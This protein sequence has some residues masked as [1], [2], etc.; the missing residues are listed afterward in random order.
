MRQRFCRG[1]DVGRGGSS[2]GRSTRTRAHR[3]EGPDGNRFG[4]PAG[5]GRGHR[6]SD[7]RAE[8]SAAPELFAVRTAVRPSGRRADELRPVRIQRNFTKHAE[9]AVLV[10]F[11]DTRVL[12]TASIEER[13]PPFLKDTGRGWVTAEYGMLPR[14]TNTRTDRE[15]ARGKQTGR[16][17]EIQRLV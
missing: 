8:T 13:E 4:L 1:D 10:E 17:Q 15:A 7:C 16:T 6:E 11:G 5:L 14:S 9:G 12:C 3:G 2:G